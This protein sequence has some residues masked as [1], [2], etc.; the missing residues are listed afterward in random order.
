MTA[1]SGKKESVYCEKECGD[2]IKAGRRKFSPYITGRR[3]K[4][5]EL[6]CSLME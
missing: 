3:L 6:L 4:L 1:L 2:S 5:G